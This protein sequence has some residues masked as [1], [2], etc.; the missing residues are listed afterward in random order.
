MLISL[1]LCIIIIAM[2]FVIKV[3]EDMQ[4]KSDEEL[5]SIMTDIDSTE[6]EINEATKEFN[7]RLH[8]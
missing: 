2:V 7:K 1:I 6:N 5:Y 8:K 3:E 4:Y